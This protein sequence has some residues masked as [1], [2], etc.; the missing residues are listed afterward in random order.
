M[1]QV[2]ALNRGGVRHAFHTRHGGVSRGLYD[3]LNC[4]LGSDDDRD[5]VLANR[6]RAV[7]MLDLPPESLFT[8][9]QYHSAEVATVG[10]GPLPAERPRADAVVTRRP[11]IAIG[12]STADC[13][14]VLFGDAEAGVIGGAHA[15]WRGALGGVMEATVA[16]MQAL[17]ASTGRIT[18]AIGPTIGPDSYEVGP[19]FPAPF[20]AQDP[21][22]QR[23]FRPAARDG[24]WMFD[25]PSYCARRLSLLG[26]GQVMETRRDT[27]GEVDDFFSY[28]RSRL[29][30]EADFGRLISVIALAD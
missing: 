7:T 21:V 23:F 8:V 30:A 11:G 1:I 12:I 10:D 19:E 18:A 2:D 29:K 3:S 27:C 15:G 9:Y 13:A 17:G 24:H 4:G 16:A 22:N 5:A 20:I 25:L 26:L 28:R 14:P 6:A